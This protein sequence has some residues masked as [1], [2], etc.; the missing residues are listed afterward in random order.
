MPITHVYSYS[1]RMTK[2]TK[3][4]IVNLINRSPEVQVLLWN[5]NEKDTIIKFGL[6]DFEYTHYKVNLHMQGSH[7][8]HTFFCYQ[9]IKSTLKRD[10]KK[11][12]I[13]LV[14]DKS[15]EIAEQSSSKLSSLTPSNKLQQN[16]SSK[17]NI[18]KSNRSSVNTQQEQLSSN[19][20]WGKQS[21]YTHRSNLD[22]YQP[23]K[24]RICLEVKPIDSS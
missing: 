11:E 1:A 20:Q 22:V 21:R 23:A 4:A 13:K 14:D 16:K 24:K 18:S 17:S 12:I 3:T 5:C 19:M 8:G 6:K 10:K 2:S 9:R 7:Q 15:G